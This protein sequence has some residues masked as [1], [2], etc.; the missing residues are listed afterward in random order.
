MPTYDMG[1]S[2]ANG[3]SYSMLR[4][5]CEAENMAVAVAEAE[6][7]FPGYK[8]HHGWCIAGGR[9][10]RTEDELE[11]WMKSHKPGVLRTQGKKE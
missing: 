5:T 3:S 7:L 10:P 9:E 2:V 1:L 6:E 4:H 8:V 11:A